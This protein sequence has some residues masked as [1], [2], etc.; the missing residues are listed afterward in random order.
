MSDFSEKV[1][2]IYNVSVALRREVT[3]NMRAV[4][5]SRIERNIDIR[6]VF[7][8]EPNEDEIECMG[9]IGTEVLSHYDEDKEQEHH[10]VIPHGP[11]TLKEGEVIA[12][13]RK[14]ELT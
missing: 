10:D 11:I 13:E 6:F 1:M 4:L 2:L 7:Y 5:I 12:F 3:A 14:E 9:Y 8:Q